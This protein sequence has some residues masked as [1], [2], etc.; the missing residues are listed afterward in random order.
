M[1][2]RYTVTISREDY[3]SDSEAV[4][5]R[6]TYEVGERESLSEALADAEHQCAQWGWLKD[7][8]G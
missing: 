8:A 6:I 3:V 5:G 4:I 2:T 1:A 7:D